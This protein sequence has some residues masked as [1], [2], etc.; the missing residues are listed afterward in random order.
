MKNIYPPDD[1][2]LPIRDAEYLLNGNSQILGRLKLHAATSD[3]HFDQRFI[4]PLERL[5]EHISALPATSSG[6]FSGEGGLFC[7]SIELA[8]LSFQASDGRIFTGAESVERRHK[9][10]P[11][12]RYFCFAAALFYP[13]GKPLGRMIVTNARGETWQKHHQSLVE[14]TLAS[15][16][17]RIYVSWPEDKAE[18]GQIQIG[19]SPYTAS[20]L[21]KILGPDNLA[22]LEDGSTHLIRDLFE[23]VSGADT[24]AKIARDVIATMW[25]KVRTREE[26]RMPENY[27]RL[28]IGTHLTPYLVGAM[29]ALVDAGKWVPNGLPF[30]VDAA[31][32]YLVWPQAGHDIVKQGKVDGHEGWPSSPSV[33]ADLLKAAGIFDPARGDDS[34]QVEVVDFEGNLHP[35][36]KLKNPFAVMESYDPADYKKSPPKTL[37]AVLAADPIAVVERRVAQAAQPQVQPDDGAAAPQLPSSKGTSIDQE[38][39]EIL[40]YEPVGSSTPVPVLS[41]REEGDA[42]IADQGTNYQEA[43]APSE[44]AEAS[45]SKTGARDASRNPSANA[46][47]VPVGAPEDQRKVKEAPEIKFSDLVPE[48]IRREMKTPLSVE[49]L[50]K[51][52]KTWRERGEDNTTM[53]MTDN[54]AAISFELLS[55][56]IR[57]I[58]DWVNEIAVAGLV[59]TAPATPGLKIMKVAIPEGSSKPREAIVISRYGCKKL[60]L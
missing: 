3:A 29:R 15:D 52:I 1:P 53:R 33:L 25:Q 6:L 54:G 49:L 50:G 12:W 14:W 5:A 42:R 18:Q 55:S 30:I 10:E 35:A 20:I 34:G 9:L 38:S 43:A 26:A 56:M 41:K 4:K 48:E 24:S 21:H 32:L 17:D 57:N 28:T 23:V 7:A 59:Y 60:G 47:S 46:T 2:G 22:W 51:V 11:R 37:V 8:F 27:G 19:P 58:P 44:K 31:G 13:I 36:F 40:N 39:G 45:D 16:T